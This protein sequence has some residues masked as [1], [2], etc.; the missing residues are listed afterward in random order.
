[1]KTQLLVDIG[2][3]RAKLATASGDGLQLLAESDADPSAPLPVPYDCEAIW[4]ANVRRRATQ[5]IAFERNDTP[6]ISVDW[7]RCSA[8]LQTRY[9]P[10][11]LGIDR[12]LGLIAC[13]AKRQPGM[14]ALVVDA[15]TAMTVDLI[16]EHGVHVGGYIVPGVDLVI[17]CFEKKT[18]LKAAE[19]PGLGELPINTAS[20]VRDGTELS[21][22]NFVR[23]MQQRYPEASLFFGGGAAEHWTELLQGSVQHV[24]Q[25]VLSGLFELA[26]AGH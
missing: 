2:H 7:Q 18:H 3:T 24:P 25:M 16:D 4:V 11:Q 12:W 8:Y 23:H 21:L 15:G 9:A 19:Y 6:V 14:P 17:D 13:N 22:L 26:I 20:A 10:D 1:M 5:R